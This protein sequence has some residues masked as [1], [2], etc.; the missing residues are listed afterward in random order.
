MSWKLQ[1][2]ELDLTYRDFQVLVANCERELRGLYLTLHFQQL[3]E[4][5]KHSLITFHHPVVEQVS[6]TSKPRGVGTKV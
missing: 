2:A 1:S 6:T 4:K 3:E 5:E